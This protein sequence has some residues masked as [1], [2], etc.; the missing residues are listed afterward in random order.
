MASGVIHLHIDMPLFSK[1]RP[2][3][4]GNG[5]FMPPEYQKKRRHMQSQIMLQYKGQPMVGPLRLEI[6]VCGEGRADA[7]N[8]IGA[9]MDA[10][11]GI[12]WVDDRVSVIPEITVKWQKASRSKSCWDITITTIGDVQ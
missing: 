9:L 10:A 4:T 11:K 5:T 8:I 6:A 7:D 1:A 3:V 12:L 2:R